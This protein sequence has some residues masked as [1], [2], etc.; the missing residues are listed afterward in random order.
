MKMI[1]L[2]TIWLCKL[3]YVSRNICTGC[4]ELHGDNIRNY[5]LIDKYYNRKIIDFEEFK[6]GRPRYFDLMSDE[7]VYNGVYRRFFRPNDIDKI[8]VVEKFRIPRKYFEWKEIREGKIT[9]EKF[10]ELSYELRYITIM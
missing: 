5:L 9:F 10:M 1:S 2:E 6:I 3:V 4:M 7:G 8:F